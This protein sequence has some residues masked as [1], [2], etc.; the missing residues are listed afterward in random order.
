M[1]PRSMLD[2]CSGTLVRSNSNRNAK[3]TAAQIGSCFNED[4]GTH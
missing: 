4:E 1:A 2:D 3:L